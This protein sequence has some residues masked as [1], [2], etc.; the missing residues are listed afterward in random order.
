M[1]DDRI[2]DGHTPCTWS[3]TEQYKGRRATD[4]GVGLWIIEQTALRKFIIG[5]S[6]TVSR[7]VDEHLSKLQAGKHNNP[8]LQT[9]YNMDSDLKIYEC[10]TANLV[11]AKMLVKALRESTRPTYLLLN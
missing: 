3:I 9:I 11:T 6:R 5:A 2:F 10:A 7:T 8:H 4:C 1:W